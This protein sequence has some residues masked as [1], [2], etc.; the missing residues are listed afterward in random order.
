MLLTKFLNDLF[1]T[2][3]FILEDADGKDHV[4]G[5]LDSKNPIKMKINL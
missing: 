3:G 4:I 5:K 2:G 1:K